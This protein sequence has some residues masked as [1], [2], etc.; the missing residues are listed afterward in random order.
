MGCKQLIFRTLLAVLFSFSSIFVYCQ[1]KPTYTI[2][3]KPEEQTPITLAIPVSPALTLSKRDSA[4]TT[5]SLDSLVFEGYKDLKLDGEQKQEGNNTILYISLGKKYPK[6]ER[7]DVKMRATIDKN[8]AAVLGIS[9]TIEISNID[10]TI[11]S[12]IE[13]LAQ[14]GYPDA[15]LEVNSDNQ[16]LH[17]TGKLGNKT[18][19]TSIVIRGYEKPPKAFIASL[20]DQFSKRIWDDALQ[21]ELIQRLQTSPYFSLDENPKL[22]F[23]RT[24]ADLYLFLKR[25]KS[26]V[27]DGII[28][29]GNNKSEKF[30]LNGGIRLEFRNVLNAFEELQFQWQRSPENAQNFNLKFDFPYLIS[31]KLGIDTGLE[32]FRQD[33][34]FASFKFSPGL[35][36]SPNWKSRLRAALHLE[37]SSSANSANNLNNTTD[38]SR[39]G[40]SLQYRYTLPNEM[41]LMPIRRRFIV[42]ASGVQMKSLS[43]VNPVLNP[44]LISQVSAE[45]LLP[46]GENTSHY[47]FL[48]TQTNWVL[49]KNKLFF[50]NELLRFGG[51]N[52]LRGFN[53]NALVGN[54]LS[55]A[56]LEYRYVIE[57]RAF[58]D[59]FFQAGKHVN[60]S[61]N[62]DAFLYSAGIGFNLSLPF[63]IMNFQIAHGQAPGVPFRLGNVKVHWGVVASF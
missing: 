5:K 32:I 24:G 42:Q 34:M 50:E 18:S 27:F 56:S 52:S 51:W 53:E 16:Y 6:I 46:L 61:V 1:N 33:T 49:A 20:T 23:N 43:D 7:K 40:L 8:I 63:G 25:K 47:M 37:Q 26:N 21:K 28:G 11:D 2:T 14:K 31:S 60:N 10:E 39:V 62:Y 58:L 36:Y 3:S 19:I 38:F 17:I 29:F 35:T 12:W 57:N 4:A 45:Y 44:Q 22:K 41:I 48:S 30:K 54:F 9:E 13:I 59:A 55:F 15:T